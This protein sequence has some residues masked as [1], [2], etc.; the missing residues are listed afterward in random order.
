MDAQ[1]RTALIFVTQGVGCASCTCDWGIYNGLAIW[2]GSPDTRHIK[3][4]Y[5]RWSATYVGQS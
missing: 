2:H 4:T 5:G 1:R 3:V